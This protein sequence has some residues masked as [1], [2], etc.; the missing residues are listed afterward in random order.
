MENLKLSKFKDENSKEVVDLFHKTFS[1]SEGNNEGKIISD[2][3]YNFITKTNRSNLHI[4]I[5][6]V[7]K[8]IIGAIIFSRIKFEKDSINAFLLAPV[9][10]HTNYQGKGIGQELIDYGH[11]YLK[12]NDVEL[13]FTYGDINFYSKIGYKL[14]SE[15]IVK[16][17]QNLSYPEGWLGQSFKDIEIQPING[18]LYCED[19]I[20][21]PEYW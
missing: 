4:F 15:Q 7:D 16:A 12:K 13:V 5:A 20:S 2:L 14:I 3:T 10:V 11:N 1:D 17:P 18:E 6:S 19:V 8:K 9:A 21:N